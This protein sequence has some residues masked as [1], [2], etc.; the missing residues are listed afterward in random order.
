MTRAPTCLEQLTPL[1]ELDQALRCRPLRAWLCQGEQETALAISHVER[2]TLWL[3]GRWAAK[4]LLAQV[5]AQRDAA[6][7]RLE[8]YDPASA[9][10]PEA[11]YIQSR[12][13]QGRHVRPSVYYCGRLQPWSL[14]IA[15]CDSAVYV[16]LATGEDSIGVDVLECC[17]L[18]PALIRTWFTPREQQQ[19]ADDPDPL[20][21][22]KCW[23][24]K[25]AAY[26]ALNQGEPFAPRRVE[27]RKDAEFAYRLLWN[28]QAI[29]RPCAIEV[30]QIGQWI[31]SRCIVGPRDSRRRQPETGSR[32][33]QPAT[34]GPATT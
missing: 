25:E 28:G 34:S 8:K 23:S 17:A 32:S 19:V 21:A 2:R 3:A 15:H 14:S 5:I 29:D 6:G 22:A 12:D 27:L 7:S 33:V 4:A 13:C 18:R 20:A 9:A 30:R 1:A 11:F 24:L 31:A 16:A 26:K 10:P